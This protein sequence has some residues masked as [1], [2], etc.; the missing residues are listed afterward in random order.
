V[1]G[2]KKH[3]AWFLLAQKADGQ[4]SADAVNVR[5]QNIHPTGFWNFL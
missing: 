1:Y 2:A 5:R 4:A 3:C